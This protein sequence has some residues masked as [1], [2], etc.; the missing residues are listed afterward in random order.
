[1]L[2]SQGECRNGKHRGTAQRTPRHTHRH[3]L[4]I[5]KTQPPR[6]RQTVTAHVETPCERAYTP[7]A[8]T[9]RTGVET[10]RTNSERLTR[11]PTRPANRATRRQRAALGCS[12]CVLPSRQPRRNNPSTS[13]QTK[14]ARLPRGD[15]KVWTTKPPK[16]RTPTTLWP[17]GALAG[18]T[19]KVH[20]HTGDSQRETAQT[21]RKTCR[22]ETLRVN[23]QPH[24]CSAGTAATHRS[25]S[26][27]PPQAGYS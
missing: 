1:L 26:R 7:R 15:T 24:P 23:T 2:P 20:K 17:A 5:N 9:L 27:N 25:H 21:I 12:H 18:R 13:L 16:P 11:L 19:H 8:D 6:T 22:L 4:G 14:N 3:A 10:R